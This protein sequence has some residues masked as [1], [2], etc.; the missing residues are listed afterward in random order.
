MFTEDDVLMIA[1]N[2]LLEG[3]SHA[4]T[5]LATQCIVGDA[6]F[7]EA[8]PFLWQMIDEI[9]VKGNEFDMAGIE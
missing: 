1:A 9:V 5:M 2:F 4:D 6:A 8:K 3:Y 7:F